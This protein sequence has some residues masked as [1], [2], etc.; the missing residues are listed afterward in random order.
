MS[1]QSSVKEPVTKSIE[2]VQYDLSHDTHLVGAIGCLQTLSMVP[3]LAGD[4]MELNYE[5]VFRLS[6]LVR[7]MHLDVQVDLFAFYRPHRHAYG[8]DWIDFIKSGV[9]EAVTLGTQT[10]G[11]GVDLNAMGFYSSAA[12]TLPA[13]IPSAYVAIWN[14]YFRDPADVAGELAENY[15]TTVASSDQTINYGL[16][17]CHLKRMWNTGMLTTLT[18][19]DYRLTLSGGE[20]D[21]YELSSL[22]GR[23]KTELE[24]E[25]FSVRYSDL[26]ES[27]FG[28]GGVSTDADQRPTLLMRVTQWLSGHDIDG[29][30]NATLGF[31]TGKGV[32]V[33]RMSFPWKFFPEHGSL[34]IMALLRIP[35]TH[36]RECHFLVYKSQPT[37]LEISGDPELYAR[38]GPYAL[39]G[40]EVFQGSGSVA[41]GNVPYGQWFRYH[42]SYAHRQFEVITGHPF[43]TSVPTSRNDAIYITH[44]EYDSMFHNIQLKHWQAHSWI[45]LQ[46]RRYVPEVNDSIFAGTNSH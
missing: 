27:V 30:D 10:L 14:R 15:F 45:D 19:A 22:Q 33:C 9:D 3:V 26:L 6:P 40:N 46:A 18:T 38:K 11:A 42:P 32:G 7:Y 1:G 39:N 36:T 13:W 21:L 35:P 31:N 20:V 16:G 2:R 4:S 25:W 34:W 12:A 8:Q 24:R 44:D 41:L 29:T 28:S 23:L 17:C 5:G 37:Y 43:L